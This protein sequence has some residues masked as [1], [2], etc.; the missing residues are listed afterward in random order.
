MALASSYGRKNIVLDESRLLE[1]PVDRLSRMIRSTFWPSL[2]RR[3]DGDMLLEI[4]ADPKNRSLDR[5]PRIYVPHGED[6]IAHHYECF[7][8]RHPESGL[9]VER[10][11]PLPQISAEYV[12]SLN[13]RPGILALA[14]RPASGPVG[15]QGL[16]SIPFVVPG[17]RFVELYNW[18]S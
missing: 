5:S 12:K 1:N 6:A 8:R 13:D 2:T 17:G 9:L 10:L 3:L 14:M 7:A 4:C 16:E 11:P 15:S 18:D